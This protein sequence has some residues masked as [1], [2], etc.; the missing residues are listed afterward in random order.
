M[1]ITTFIY[2]NYSCQVDNPKECVL[3]HMNSET[4]QYS[5]REMIHR[6]AIVGRNPGIDYLLDRKGLKG[7]D[8]N[9]GI[10]YI[11]VDHH[12]GISLRIHALCHIQPGTLPDIVI[13]FED[14]GEDLILRY[15]EIGPFALLSNEDANT[16]SF[17]EEQRWHIYYESESLRKIRDRVDLD[18]FRAPG[19]FDDVYVVLV[20]HDPDHVPEVV[21]VRLEEMTDDG[22]RFRGIMLNEP[23]GGFGVHEG[24]M[25]VVH[26]AE[27]EDG[28]YLRAGTRTP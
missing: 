26:V 7:H 27:D 28:R 15:D 20:S 5:D 18:K 24:E 23:D 2:C 13:N 11:Y 8:V 6:W 4:H 9:G 14:H 16:L 19:Y 22:T 1:G 17:L 21:W 25:I 3:N 10:G 12:Q